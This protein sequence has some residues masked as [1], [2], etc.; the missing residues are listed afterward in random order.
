MANSEFRLS[1]N[2]SDKHIEDVIDARKKIGQYDVY[3]LPTVPV[4]SQNSL[5][6]SAYS[7]PAT[8]INEEGRQTFLEDGAMWVNEGDLCNCPGEPGIINIGPTDSEITVV[9]VKREGLQ[10][11][12]DENKWNL[13]DDAVPG[14]GTHLGESPSLVNLVTLVGQPL[15]TFGN[16]STINSNNNNNKISE[17]NEYLVPLSSWDPCDHPY[18]LP[19]IFLSHNRNCREELNVSKLR[20]IKPPNIPGKR[21]GLAGRLS[22]FLRKRCIR[23]SKTSVNDVSP[24][25]FKPMD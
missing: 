25:T 15:Q 7:T 10:Y 6:R 21:P 24:E 20:V 2:Q 5:Y 18:N 17:Y 4:I 8:G 22:N 1:I 16:S 23:K 11:K 9:R 19:D 13:N 12:S 14:D 3:R